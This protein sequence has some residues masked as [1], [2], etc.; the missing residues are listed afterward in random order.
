VSENLTALGALM[1]PGACGGEPD[2]ISKV[3]TT[4]ADCFTH[5]CLSP[6]GRP[7]NVQQSPTSHHLLPFQP[8]APRSRPV[9]LLL[10]PLIHSSHACHLPFATAQPAAHPSWTRSLPCGVSNWDLAARL[11][12]KP[13]PRHPRHPLVQSLCSACSASR[14]NLRLRG[15]SDKQQSQR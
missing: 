12:P 10:G 11:A 14:R 2:S 8:H 13:A 7:S 5:G 6:H 3:T 9:A 15:R 4:V 1:G